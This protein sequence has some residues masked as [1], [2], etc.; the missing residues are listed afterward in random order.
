MAIPQNGPQHI[1]TNKI[2]QVRTQ[3]TKTVYTS[4]NKARTFMIK[5]AMYSNICLAF[6][7]I[8]NLSCSNDYGVPCEFAQ[9]T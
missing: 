4:N 3:N 2:T 5:L 1:Q 8:A 6:N 7:L 9:A